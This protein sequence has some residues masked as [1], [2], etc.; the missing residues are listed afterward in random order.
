MPRDVLLILVLVAV[1]LNLALLAGAGIVRWRAVSRSARPRFGDVLPAASPAPVSVLPKDSVLPIRERT[2]PVPPAATEPIRFSTRRSA[3]P[4]HRPPAARPLPLAGAPSGRQ[5]VW[6]SAPALRA[7]EQAPVVPPHR[8]DAWPVATPL[9]AAPLRVEPVRAESVR[10]DA[11][12][13]PALRPPAPF[14]SVATEP[15]SEP[16]VA[17]ADAEPAAPTEPVGDATPAATSAEPAESIET[18]PALEPPGPAEPGY[19]KRSRGANGHGRS[20]SKG[21]G[22]ARRFVLPEHGDEDRGRT[23]RAIEAFLGEPAPTGTAS[24]HRPRRRARRQRAGT[25]GEPIVLMAA[26]GGFDDLRQTVGREGA[27][28]FAAAYGEALRATL[29]S[30]DHVTDLGQGRLR[31]VVHA[32]VEGANALT[33]RAKAV[34]DPWLRLAP[35]PLALRVRPLPPESRAAQSNGNG[36]APVK[37]TRPDDPQQSLAAG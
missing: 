1:L 5:Q 7:A 4:A 22:R 2:I 9:R 12:P 29:R 3:A 21:G 36:H 18:L 30:G 33:E 16:A 25:E 35:V 28:K 17:P 11:W 15:V 37:P 32:D 6:P 14:A 13:L 23:E 31:L 20:A 26:L 19:A 10:A 8:P 27:T 24:A 34:C